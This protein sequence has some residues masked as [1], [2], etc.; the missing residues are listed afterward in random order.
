MRRIAAVF[1]M[2]GL[3]MMAYAA[4]LRA[5]DVTIVSTFEG[6]KGPSWK[7]TADISGAVGPKHVV[8]FD[9]GGFVVHDKATGKVLYRM[10]PR[11]FWNHV[12]PPLDVQK[13]PN[14]AAAP[15]LAAR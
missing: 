9:G 12:E 8:D 2:A 14:P 3:A 13:D 4:T 7:Q 5:Q 6:D 10:A 11:E 1:A 15:R